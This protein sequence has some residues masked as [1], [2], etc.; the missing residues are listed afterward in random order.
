MIP[1][2]G[3]KNTIVQQMATSTSSVPAMKRIY[4]ISELLF[5]YIIFAA[6]GNH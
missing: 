5:L 2:S 3:I 6:D 4:E 1:R